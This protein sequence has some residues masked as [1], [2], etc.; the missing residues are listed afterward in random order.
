MR[1]DAWLRK[2]PS[3][4]ER[5]HVVELLARGVNEAHGRGEQLAGLEPSR[6]EVSGASCDLA[7]ALAGPA[8]R[9][10]LAPEREGDGPATAASDVYAAG[11]IVWE[12]LV[13]RPYAA[14]PSHLSEARPDLPG[15]LCDAV[16][17]CLESS[18][19][20][21]PADLSYVAELAS[22][23]AA[24]RGGGSRSAAP[25][26][27]P[28][29]AAART[30][31]PKK[32]AGRPSPTFDGHGREPSRSQVPL[33]AAAVVLLAGAGAGYFWMTREKGQPSPPA[34]V[35]PTAAAAQAPAVAAPTAE[36]TPTAEPAM[37]AAATQP[38]P[39]P[40]PTTAPRPTPT[41]AALSA[42]AAPARAVTAE[43]APTTAA[44]TTPAATTTAPAAPP[45]AAAPVTTS[46][47]AAAADAPRE[48][49]VLA[50][51]SP[52]AVKR[53]GRVLFD[54]HG[55]GLTADLHARLVGVRDSPHGMMVVRQK[56]SGT[57]CNVLVQLDDSVKPAAYA[58][59]LE[60]PQGRQS[61]ALTFTV[62]K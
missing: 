9:H 58:I 25:K 8:A 23:A 33:I 17:A 2:D 19:D 7:D 47:P 16:M 39:T 13:G 28:K 52:L 41:P 44:A 62:T 30:E 31:R 11:A 22:Q 61:N 35:A 37:A 36:P 24:Q 59:V 4:V 48:S 42:P 1:L 34:A 40:T 18:P 38:G 46:A 15:D 57:L 54:L 43:P 12:T 20:W 45:P 51:L 60:D 55:T 10:Y 5:L 29:P 3:V 50:T 56:C 21:R 26:P 14:S 53:P 27:A 6:I 49:A 32:A